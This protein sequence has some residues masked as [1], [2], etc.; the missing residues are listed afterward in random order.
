MPRAEV[1]AAV[2]NRLKA[3][4]SSPEA[5]GARR[6]AGLPEAPVYITNDEG[7]TPGDG[8]V[9]IQIQFPTGSSR[10]FDVAGTQYIEEGTIRVIVNMP[11]GAGT[12][13]AFKMADMLAAIFR[14]KKFGGVQTYAPSPAVVDDRNDQGMYWPLAFAVPYDFKFRDKS[15]QYD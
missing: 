5:I 4:W 11:S 9:F 7:D 15:G 13:A 1:A 10:Q 2:E 6:D 8:S 12:D 14:G 3:R